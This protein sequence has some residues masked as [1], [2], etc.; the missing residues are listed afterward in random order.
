MPTKIAHCLLF[1]LLEGLESCPPHARKVALAEVPFRRQSTEGIYN[2]SKSKNMS[3]PILGYHVVLDGTYLR[4][5]DIVFE[6]YL[7]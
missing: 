1:F 6:K 3:Y 5:Y 7:N 2:M 4:N